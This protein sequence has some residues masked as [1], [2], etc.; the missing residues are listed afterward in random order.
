MRGRPGARDQQA[1]DGFRPAVPGSTD[2]RVAPARAPGTAEV[3]PLAGAAASGAD[4]KV[5]AGVVLRPE[6]GRG[7]S[8][9]GTPG[10]RDHSRPGCPVVPSSPWANSAPVATWSSLLATPPARKPANCRAIVLPPCARCFRS[11]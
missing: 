2:R 3:V 6:D 5:R 11:L 9:R 8:V 10:T 4:P 1:G 7:A